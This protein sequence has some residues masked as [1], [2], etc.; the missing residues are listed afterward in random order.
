VAASPPQGY[1]A[2]QRDVVI[3][4]YGRVTFGAVG[5]RE[6]YGLPA[7]QAIDADIKERTYDSS[8]DEY[9]KV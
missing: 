6:N 7:W 2:Q 3:P 8:E 4:F 1:V 5:C 9:E